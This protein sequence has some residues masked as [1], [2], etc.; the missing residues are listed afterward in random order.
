MAL[1]TTPYLPLSPQYPPASVILPGPIR[2]QAAASFP[3][4]LAPLLPPSSPVPAVL[5][6]L[7][8]LAS[9]V[10][11][12]RH[13]AGAVAFDPHHLNEESL[14]VA[15]QLL[16]N[17]CPLREACGDGDDNPFIS[18]G[19]NSSAPSARPVDSYMANHRLRPGAHIVPW[20]GSDS[21]EAAL[22]ISGLLYLKELLPDWP[23]NL[24]GYAVL[25]ELLRQHVDAVMLQGAIDPLLDMYGGGGGGND[26]DPYCEYYSHTPV[27]GR[28]T[29]TASWKDA[30]FIA[31]SPKDAHERR[32]AALVFVCLVGNTVSLVADQN[33]GRYLPGDRYRRDVYQRC[34]RDVLGGGGETMRRE[35]DFAL[36]RLLD[37]RNIKGEKWDDRV[38]LENLLE[39]HLG[40][41]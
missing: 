33:E 23:R 6:S 5:A 16:T 14:S 26:D 10:R 29:T 30:A 13:S 32:R 19:S 21:L 2:S 9:T 31:A 25:L 27:R 39:E 8:I 34:L 28:D 12:A 41:N 37:M 17:P 38:A 40:Y 3:H 24:G 11:L 20:A 15:H 4:I 36:L 35:S 7:S 22:R 1:A 18:G